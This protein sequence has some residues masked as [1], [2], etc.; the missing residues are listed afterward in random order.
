MNKIRALALGLFIT[1]TSGLFLSPVA[2]AE[3]AVTADAPQIST[4]EIVYV[5]CTDV[6]P[7]IDGVIDDAVWERAAVIDH[8]RQVNP[9]EGGVP[10]Q[11]TEARILYDKDAL[12]IAI[13]AYDTEPDK[14]VKTVNVR[15]APLVADDW[16]SIAIDSYNNQRDGFLFGMN[17][18]GTRSD[19]YIENNSSLIHEWDGIWYGEASVDE[20]GWH[21][22]MKIPTKTLSFSPD[23]TEWGLNI[24][25]GIRRTNEDIRWTAISRNLGYQDMTHLG[26]LRG[27]EGLEQGIGLDVQV[28]GAVSWFDDN[29]RDD[30]GFEFDPSINAFYN[31]T[32]SLTGSLTVNPDFSEA[33]VDTRQINLTRFALFFPETRD[34]FL[35]DVGIFEFAYLKNGEDQNG[36]PFFTRS[37]GLNRD[38]IADIY[39]G[40]KLTGRVGKLNL[41]FMDV[42]VD[43]TDN[44]ETK[45]LSVGRVAYNVLD[46]SSVGAIFTNGDPNSKDNNS[47]IGTDFRYHTSNFRGLGVVNASAWAQ[48]SFTTGIDDGQWAWG[49]YLDMP[50]EPHL[51]RLMYTDFGENFETAMGFTNRT[52]YRRYKA[53]YRYRE[54]PQGSFLRTLDLEEN[55]RLWTNRDNEIETIKSDFLLTATTQQ[56]DKLKIAAHYTREVLDEPFFLPDNLVVP[57]GSYDFTSGEINFV[58]GEGHPISFEAKAECCGYFNGQKMSL[59][60]M[61][62]FHYSPYWSLK[63]Q[64][65]RD[66]IDL[67]QGGTD[68]HLASFQGSI[69]FTPDIEWSNLIQYDN[70]S[71]NIGVNSRFRWI[72]KEGTEFFVIVNQGVLA[73]DGRFFRR[74]SEVR[75]KLSHTFRF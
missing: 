18:L 11:R 30:S 45:N 17:A 8:F 34:F 19:F 40:A 26:R 13:H 21:V 75:A 15:D 55:S 63:L 27:L 56:S 69:Y 39:G 74:S 61:V 12:Y 44:I 35:R 5:P 70:L 2:L 32:P 36:R 59:L 6:A 28:E 24:F 71:G 42:Q 62:R 22:E 3:C 37:I 52:G 4:P 31:F 43:N 54:R 57:P 33:P 29:F 9:V 58:W 53:Q 73:E 68:I 25:R 41:G 49:L 65:N 1:L 46:E 66:A 16:V 23:S 48:R 38:G 14:I 51:L 20:E 60:G 7:V 72:I 64:Y 50:N 47:L 10:S 67:P